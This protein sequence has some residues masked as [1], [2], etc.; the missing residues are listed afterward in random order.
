MK[1]IMKIFVM[2]LVVT[3]LSLITVSASAYPGSQVANIQPR[4]VGI[5]EAI[6][7]LDISLRGEA[8]VKG[9]VELQPGYT[10]S[11]TVILYMDS[12]SYVKSWRAKGSSS[13]TVQEN[14]FVAAGHVY[15]ATLSATIYNSSGQ[16][17]DTITTTSA[18]VYY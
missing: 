14:H 5:E 9:F 3:M 13:I 4:Y 12:G 7:T 16:R 10:G 2:L 11:V 15:Y 1:K 18:E 6:S 8:N 17:V